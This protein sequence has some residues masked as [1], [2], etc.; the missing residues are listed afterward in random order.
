MC[1]Y[2]A[3]IKFLYLLFLWKQNIDD[4]LHTCLLVWI[5][6]CVVFCLCDFFVA[7]CL[8]VWISV[9]EDCCLFACVDFCLFVWIF[10]CVDFCLSGFLFVCI[11]VV[12]ACVDFCLFVCVDFFVC[13]RGFLFFVLLLL[14]LLVLSSVSFMLEENRT[15]HTNAEGRCM[16]CCV[17]TCLLHHPKPTRRMK[18]GR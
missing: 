7:F 16:H 1:F 11:S 6:V 5:S 2:F 10:V 12:F 17:T 14:L 9:C 8:R 18:R 4:C 13:L 15:E 3:R